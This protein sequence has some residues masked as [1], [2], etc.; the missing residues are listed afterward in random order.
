MC[1]EFLGGENMN[2][3]P[4]ETLAQANEAAIYNIYLYLAHKTTPADNETLWSI[5]V[6]L[7][8]ELKRQMKYKW[9]DRD[10]YRLKILKNAVSNNHF[11]ANTRIGNFTRSKSGLTACSF[12]NQNGEVFVVFKG[13]GRGE[14]IDNGE[15]LSGIPETN[16]YITYPNG[17]KTYT[18]VKND[19][20][21]D[22]QTEA[23]NWFSKL[24][25]K[26]SWDENSNI[27]VS[28]HSKGGNKAQF[29]T[30]H[31]GVVKKCFSFNG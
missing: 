29:I 10:I 17:R 26:N 14:W 8:A 31:S 21:T 15:G 7:E 13:T 30:I 20:A 11:L 12:T 6:G 18:T 25:H 3:I 19:F 1:I 22:Q 5:S 24:C 27:T 28:G 23:F 2:A 16:T 9:K 4:L